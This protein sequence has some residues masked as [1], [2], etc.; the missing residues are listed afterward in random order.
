MTS[1][2]YSTITAY[3]AYLPKKCVSNA[4]LEKQLNTNDDWIRERVGIH[5]RHIAEETENVSDLATKAIQ[6]ALERANISAQDLDGIIVATFTPDMPMPSSAVFVQKKLGLRHGYAMDINAACSGFMYALHV[7]DSLIQSGKN[8]RIAVVGAEIFSRALDWKDR[9]TAV[10]FGDGAGAVILEK[11]ENPGIYST[12]VYSDGHYSHLLYAERVQEEHNKQ[13]CHTHMK[14]SEVMR[15]A[16]D[17]IG[18]AVEEALVYNN[19]AKEAIDWF[20]PHQANR[21]I[22]TS[23]ARRFDIPLDKFVITIDKHANTSA[24]S[25]PLALFEAVNDGRIQKN[26]LLMMESMGAGFTW[27]SSLIRWTI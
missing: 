8:K 24:A 21:R 12:H 15:H 4:A 1:K 17:R 7:A 2:I 10:L 26:H 23:V 22:I 27:G 13:Y 14:G 3:G 16:T 19:I 25:I 11:S 5:Q 6:N 9:N 18:Q 20:I